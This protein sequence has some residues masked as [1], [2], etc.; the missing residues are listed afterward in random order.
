[1]WDRFKQRL[2]K[3]RQFL[4]SLAKRLWRWL[5]GAARTLQL[6]PGTMTFEGE[7]VMPVTASIRSSSTVNANDDLALRVE[8][9][10]R[11]MGEVHKRVTKLD[12]KMQAETTERH[13]I[14]DALVE[15]FSE[16]LQSVRDKIAATEE[17]ALRVDASALPVIGL[18]IVLSGIPHFLSASTVLGVT[19]FITALAFLLWALLH[20]WTDQ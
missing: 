10:E 1:M 11:R 5:T 4:G 8:R 20:F 15:R 17:D 2:S 12:G 3:T 19:A 18:G 16:D 14:I 7:S 13:K 6:Q 9:L